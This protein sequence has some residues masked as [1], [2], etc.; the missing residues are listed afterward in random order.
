M[1]ENNMVFGNIFVT[2]T[3]NK[4]YVELSEKT[5]NI[6][7]IIPS[8]VWYCYIGPIVRK[9]GREGVKMIQTSTC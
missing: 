1:K 2:Q 7:T 4:H 5:K 6:Y 9:Y 8:Q 3:N